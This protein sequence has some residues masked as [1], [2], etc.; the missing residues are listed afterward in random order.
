MCKTSKKH[1]LFLE[2]TTGIF[3]LSSKTQQNAIS[4]IFTRK[5]N[6]KF[7]DHNIKKLCPLSLAS[8]N[9]VFDVERVYPRIV[10]FFELLASKAVSSIPPLASTIIIW[11][12][13]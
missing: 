9:P 4:K 13:N 7:A 11:Y 12:T 6:G 10:S 2:T 5:N 3:K 1:S 8:T